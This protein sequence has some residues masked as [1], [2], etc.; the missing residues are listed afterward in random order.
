MKVIGLLLA[1]VGLWLLFGLAPLAIKSAGVF[2]EAAWPLLGQIGDNFGAANAL[3]SCLAFAAAVYAVLQGQEALR[4]QRQEYQ[5]TREELARTA[6]AQRAAADEQRR[7]VQSQVMAAFMDELGRPSTLAAVQ[8]LEQQ[9]R[10]REDDLG[11]AV[12]RWRDE[13]QRRVADGRRRDAYFELLRSC[14]RLEMIVRRAMGLVQRAV[15]DVNFA[16]LL[17]GPDLRDVMSVVEDIA[18]A[19]NPDVD[20]TPFEFLA[21]LP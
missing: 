5:L 14:A 7:M 4:L 10:R 6:D 1:A 17:I 16:A 8:I 9:G 18:T 13:V 2:D 12:R 20:R 3:F 11:E 21:T 19:L 15:I